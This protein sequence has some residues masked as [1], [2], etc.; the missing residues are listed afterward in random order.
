LTAFPDYFGDNIK[1]LSTSR[2]GGNNNNNSSNPKTPTKQQT[3][4]PQKPTQI[5]I[6]DNNAS[7]NTSPNSNN[8][9]HASKSSDEA[10]TVDTNEDEDADS[11]SM[12][13]EEGC[14]SQESESSEK[15]GGDSLGFDTYSREDMKNLIVS[16]L[17]NFTGGQV[18]GTPIDNSVTS[19]F[20]A[21]R[22]VVLCSL[23]CFIFDEIFNQKW[24]TRRLNDAIRRIFK[25]LEFRENYNPTLIKMCCDNLRFLSCL[26]TMIFQKD[27]QY[28]INIINVNKQSFL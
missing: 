19:T 1:V 23:T 27:I 5:T 28:A 20:T 15:S 4:S 17:A 13:N 16:T 2:Q 18:P 21:S 10:P 7:L 12:D 3:S 22:C 24:N 25:D 9:S 8:T 6:K 14:L 26:A 11:E